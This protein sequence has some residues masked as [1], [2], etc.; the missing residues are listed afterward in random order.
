[1]IVLLCNSEQFSA[2]WLISQLHN[3][4]VFGPGWPVQVDKSRFLTPF[5]SSHYFL[6]KTKSDNWVNLKRC[7]KS[8]KIGPELQ[9]RKIYLVSVRD[10]SAVAFTNNL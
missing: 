1:M 10:S 6:K 2:Y 8:P 7:S 4:V 5:S 9:K 3:F